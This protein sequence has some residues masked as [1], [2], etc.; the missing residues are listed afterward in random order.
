[1]TVHYSEVPY[2]PIAQEAK[3]QL[4]AALTHLKA[5]DLALINRACDYANA[6]HMGQTRQSGEPYIT[7]PI[8]VATELASW[9]LDATAICA[10]LMHDV[11][12]DTG[13]TKL[14]L[15]AE[16]NETIANI[17]DGLSKL[18]KLEYEDKQQHQAE[19]FRKMI[20]AMVQDI[21]VIVIKLADRLHNMR[22]LDVM[23]P[24][25]QRRIANETLEIYAQLANRI[26]LNN[27]YRELQDLSFQ[28]LYPNRY[29]VMTKA[30]KASRR[31]RRDVV[32]KVL[33]AFSQRLLAFNIEAK[34]KG[35]EKN[36]YSIYKK[37]QSKGLHF[38]DVMDIYGFR[39]VVNSVP[40]CYLA[41]GALH[42]LY[43]P[44]PGKVKDYIAIPK[45]NGYQSLHT[46]L[47]GPYGLPIE[48]QIRTREM[49]NI[50]DGGVASHW[51]YKSDGT[52]FDQANVRT[53]QWLQNILDLQAESDNAIEFLEHVK[54]DL[55]PDEV[56]VFT[57]K[58]KIIVMP[59]GASPIDFAYA[60]HTDI[61][62]RCVAARINNTMAPLR[63]KLKTGDTIEIITSTKANPNPAW[64][65]FV[66]T[67]RARSAIRNYVK[68][69]SR[70]D[71]VSLGENLLNRALAS[72][73]PRDILLSE[74]VK[75]AYLTSLANKN[76]TFEDVLYDVGMGRTLPVV[77]AKEL[78]SLAGEHFGDTIKLSPITISDNETN[79]VQLAKCCAPIPGDNI[80]AVLI[81]EQGLIIHRDNCSNLLKS[82]PEYQLDANWDMVNQSKSYL[83]T[84]TITAVDGHGLLASIANIISSEDANIE[85][86]S[87]PSEKQDGVEGFITFTFRLRVKNVQ[88]INRIMR[89]MH[90]IAQIHKIIRN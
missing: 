25:K 51:M 72:L 28:H 62:H 42:T 48:V 44:K 82:D 58:G 19:S 17:V 46:T 11:L 85:S 43:K 77:V 49:D 63:T 41:L 65:S 26:G 12:E 53:H 34:I 2:A 38:A 6:A 81:K 32:G 88:Q 52:S 66:A 80:R 5:D 64:L 15:A 40:A 78:I 71:A 67:G 45:N 20:L 21:R 1:M 33:Q 36:L 35:R 3:N 23:R 50:A 55:F 83:C 57:P 56:Y 7:H 74:E 31:N 69:M 86:V 79:S 9:H 22:T 8:A 16:F 29:K 60:V 68:N 76:I 70:K 89:D 47:V 39:V 27:V 4:F 18:E 30:V 87:T 61:G 10:G 37:M 84:M 14:Q 24:E 73:L 90:S 75:D 54:V 13:T 59:R